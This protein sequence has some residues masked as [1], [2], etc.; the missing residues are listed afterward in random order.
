MTAR[1][2]TAAAAVLLVALTQG[3]SGAAKAVTLDGGKR[4]RATYTAVVTEATW[5]PSPE[6]IGVEP[7]ADDRELCTAG[8]CDITSIR[9]GVPP[10]S[11]HGRFVAKAL[12]P[13]ELIG[14]I[15][16][17]NSKGQAVLESGDFDFLMNCCDTTYTLTLSDARLA[18]GLY[19][20]VV[21]DRGGLGS[22]QVTVDYIANPPDRTKA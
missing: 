2:F 22:V 16:L 9:L 4:T 17:Y 6:R 20:L 13:R 18:P 14:S 8:S 1:R 12:F 11:R 5:T 3:E 21:Y 15:G 19:T 7:L 10:R